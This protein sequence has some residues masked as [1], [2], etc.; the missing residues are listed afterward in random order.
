[1][2]TSTNM[3]ENKP[4]H[5]SLAEQTIKRF[6]SPESAQRSANRRKIS[7]GIFIVNIILIVL[8]Y[9]FFAGKKPADEYASSSFN[10]KNLQ[11]RFSQTR[12]KETR[13]YI[14]TLS[15]RTAD[16]GAT[17]AR[18]NNGIADLV[19]LQGNTVVAQKPLGRNTPVLALKPGE[20]DTQKAVIEQFELKLFADNHPELVVLESRSLLRADRPYVP[21]RAEVRIHAEQPVSTSLNF[22][23]EVDR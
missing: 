16:G 5:E 23:Y 9:I 19:I 10:Y 13:D 6:R 20:A 21:F 11:F 22:K 4:S 12:D 3:N 17:T 8:L 14:F 15:T 2:D 18:F 1:M 7:T